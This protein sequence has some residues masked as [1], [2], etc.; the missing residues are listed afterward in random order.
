MLRREGAWR[1][2]RPIVGLPTG[3]SGDR[4]SHPEAIPK[5]SSCRSIT[6]STRVA[7]AADRD[8]GTCSGPVP[9]PRC[10]ISALAGP[11]P[12]LSPTHRQVNEHVA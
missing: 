8:P 2:P 7:T 9:E 1:P 10:V 3:R 4:R 11:N 6:S 5:T 12:G